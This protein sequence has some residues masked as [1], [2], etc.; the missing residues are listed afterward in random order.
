MHAKRQLY[1]PSKIK[2]HGAV[3][4]IDWAAALRFCS[5]VEKFPLLPSNPMQTVCNRY[6]HLRYVKTFIG[7]AGV[8]AFSRVNT[9]SVQ[10]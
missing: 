2:V 6:S 4:C 7:S 3:N 10:D 9:R 5:V 8:V 1:V